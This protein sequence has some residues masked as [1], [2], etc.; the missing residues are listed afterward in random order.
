M[1]ITLKENVQ[2]GIKVFYVETVLLST[3]KPKSSLAD[4]AHLESGILFKHVSS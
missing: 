1:L 3:L 4:C 2:P